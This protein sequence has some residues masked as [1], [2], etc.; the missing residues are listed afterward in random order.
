LWF[1]LQEIEKYGCI[2]VRDRNVVALHYSAIYQTVFD[3]IFSLQK[4]SAS[5][6]HAFFCLKLS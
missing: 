4:L 6:W 2:V 1:A 5:D 3:A